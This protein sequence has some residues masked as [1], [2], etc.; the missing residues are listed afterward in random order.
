MQGTKREVQILQF[1]LVEMNPLDANALNGGTK[2][3][4]VLF[5]QFGKL[6]HD[7]AELLNLLVKE[8]DFIGFREE[9]HLFDT[10]ASQATETMVV[11]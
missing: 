11:E 4:E 2:V 6:C 10:T 8:T 7:T 3:E 5:G 9:C 1:F